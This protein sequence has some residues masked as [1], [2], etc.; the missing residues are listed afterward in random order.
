M[1]LTLSCCQCAGEAED[2]E[3]NTGLLGQFVEY[4][5][6]RKTV[7]LEQLATEFKL[8]TTDVIDRINGLEAMGRI[9]GVMDERG[10]VCGQQA[11]HRN[12][13]PAPTGSLLTSQHMEEA[14]RACVQAS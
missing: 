1:I 5:K 6:S 2:A 3:E 13:K 14:C 7:P 10:K 8:R 9:T 12:G 4:I 11:M